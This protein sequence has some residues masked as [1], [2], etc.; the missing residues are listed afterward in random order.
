MIT[1]KTLI[2]PLLCVSLLIGCSKNSNSLTIEKGVLSV[3]VEIGYPPMEYYGTD[4]SLLG[5]DIDLTKALAEKLNLQVNFIDTVW[6]GI[7]AGLDTD[8]YDIAVNVTVLPERQKKYNFTKPYIN[9]FIVIVTR[10]D[11]RIKINKA[12]DILGYR[13]AF[14]G[15]TTAQYFAERLNNQGINFTSFSYDKIINC[16]DDLKLGRVDLVLV[17]NIAGYYYAAKE[18]SAFE[19]AWVN[20]QNDSLENSLE[21][22]KELSEELIG[23]CLKKG[24]DALT[25]ILDKALDELLADGTLA[26]ISYRYFGMR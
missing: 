26:G 10:R 3:G 5:F 8:R 2:F 11:P 18:K 17:D 14:Q 23:I 16:F 21:F 15:N 13:A 12:E 25:G 9:S 6:E 1:K 7:L 24:N 20:S 4:G 19:I 22:S